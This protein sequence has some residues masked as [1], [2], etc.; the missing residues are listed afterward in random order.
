MADPVL[1]TVAAVKL[2]LGITGSTEDA[3]LLAMLLGVE[4][5]VK[6]W[7][8]RNFVAATYTE[9]LDGTG[10]DLLVLR[11]RPIIDVDSVYVDCAGAYGQASDAF[12]DDS[13]WIIG[14]DFSV[15]G[16]ESSDTASERQGGMLVAIANC[17]KWPIG[18]GNIK[19]VYTAGY[20]VIP[21]EI[22]TAV[23]SLVGAMRNAA[24]KGAAAPIAGETFGRYSY[25][26]L[27]NPSQAAAAG[28]IAAQQ[29]L[30]AYRE[31]AI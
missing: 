21:D 25:Y 7:T 11:H 19:C 8:K 16:L 30:S 24:E 27:S 18:R 14:S 28:L 5:A 9:Y 15:P 22:A 10:R 12:D 4:G 23:N 13:E 31:V 26:L 29:I 2:Q 3:K 17:G 6:R 20:P 1:S